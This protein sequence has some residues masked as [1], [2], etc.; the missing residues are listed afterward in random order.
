M[1]E[2]FNHPALSRST[3]KSFVRSSKTGAFEFENKKEITS[4]ALNFGRAFHLIM[5][6]LDEYE[7]QVVI[8]DEMKRPEPDKTFASKLNK[9]W[10]DEFF[11]KAETVIT[12]EENI[13]IHNMRDE[14]MKTE[15]YKRAFKGKGIQSITF[16]KDFYANVDGLEL[17]ALC[18][19]AIEYGD[20]IICI[21]WKTTTSTLSPDD[22]YSPIREIKKWDLHFQSTHYKKVIEANTSKEVIF[23][24]FFVEKQGANEC[25]PVAI[26]NESGLAIEGEM[27]WNRAVANYRA[28][29]QGEKSG[30]DK[31]LSDGILIL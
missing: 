28:Y 25:L 19:V 16:E 1:K 5:E 18:D 20:R 24:F 12:Q 11:A 9:Q 30:I 10:K 8:Y 13:I 3:L 31:Y 4:D 6:S 22:I 27:L 14:V 2:Y 29:K 21:D 7:K 15:F 26:S 17:K 23:V